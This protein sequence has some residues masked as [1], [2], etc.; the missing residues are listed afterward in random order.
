MTWLTT[1]GSVK[2]LVHGDVLQLWRQAQAADRVHQ[3]ITNRQGARRPRRARFGGDER[4]VGH[5]AFSRELACGRAGRNDGGQAV[6]GQQA[7][8][9]EEQEEQQQEKS[10][11]RS[12]RLHKNPLVL[13]Q[14]DH[15]FPSAHPPGERCPFAIGEA[16]GENVRAMRTEVRVYWEN[17]DGSPRYVTC[18]LRRHVMARKRSPRRTAPHPGLC[19]APGSS[20]TQGE[21]LPRYG[22]RPAQVLLPVVAV[23]PSALCQLDDPLPDSTATSMCCPVEVATAPSTA[24]SGKARTASF[25]ACPSDSSRDRGHSSRAARR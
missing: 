18:L 4:Q 12:P 22:Y 7:D 23:E 14:Q 21:S 9:D 19:H 20:P 16:S 10:R 3:I 2:A 1:V 6:P 15:S 8:P 25:P 24:P 13:C 5:G 11:S 17:H